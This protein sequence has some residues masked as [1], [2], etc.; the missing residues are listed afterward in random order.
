[1]SDNG[2]NKRRIGDYSLNEP[3][4][5]S[6]YREWLTDALSYKSLNPANE[7]LLKIIKTKIDQ[8]LRLNLKAEEKHRASH[9]NDYYFKDEINEKKSN[10]A[11]GKVA[12]G[13]LRKPNSCE[14]KEFAGEFKITSGKVTTLLLDILDLI[15]SKLGGCKND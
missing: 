8:V 1:M 14:R 3:I 13:V 2:K 7:E 5:K 6:N 9:G 15:N 4:S 12:F 11:L 10:D